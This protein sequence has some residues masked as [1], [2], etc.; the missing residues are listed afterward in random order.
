V[1]PAGNPQYPQNVQEHKACTLQ[2]TITT[3]NDHFIVLG[4]TG[5]GDLENAFVIQIQNYG[6]SREDD[7]PRP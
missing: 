2:T 1:R 6:P 7:A 5:L 3:P 4:V